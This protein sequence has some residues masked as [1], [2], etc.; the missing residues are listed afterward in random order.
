MRPAA[1][2]VLASVLLLGGCT[3]TYAIVASVEGGRVTFR[4]D[5]GRP[6]LLAP[7]A[8]ITR[9]SVTAYDAESK[10]EDIVWSF[11]PPESHGSNSCI[12]DFPIT[13]GSVPPATYEAVPAQPLREGIRYEVRA[14]GPGITGGGAFNVRRMPILE[15][16]GSP[17][18]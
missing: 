10:T 15:N 2:V 16:L 18:D 3:Y 9:F 8:C 5:S 17:F 4:P 1:F 14:T 11:E 6:K 13:Y 7:D 12:A